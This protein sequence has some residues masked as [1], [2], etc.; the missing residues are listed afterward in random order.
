MLWKVARQWNQV[1][2]D[3]QTKKPPPLQ[4]DAAAP[5]ERLA[6]QLRMMIKTFWYS[7]GRNNLI[8]LGIAVCTVVALTA[9]LQIK[10]N[11]WNKPFYDALSLKDFWEFLHQLAVFGEIAGALLALNVA[12]AFLR[13]LSKLKLREGLTRDLFDQWLVPR[14]AF[15]LSNAGEIGQNPDQ[16]IHED[17]R[18][19]VDLSTD[20]GI[21]LLQST[22]LLVCFITVLWTVSE[23]IT[24]TVGGTSFAVPGY[25]VWCALI[26]AGIASF[27]SW[28]VGRP[29]IALNAERYA[30]EADLR[31][32]LVRVNERTEAIALYGGETD[33]KDYL[34]REFDQVLSMMRRL[35]S[36]VTRLTWVTAGYGWFTIVAPFIVA[37]PG[38]FAGDMSLGG[39][40]M[41]VGAFNQVQQA[42]RW[43]VDNFSTIADWRATLLRVASF[44]LALLEMDRLGHEAGRLELVQTADDRLVF[45]QVGI[46]SPGGCTR[47][48]EK[49][50]VINPA[51]RVLIIGK[52]RGVKTILFSA[53][54]GLWPFGRGRILLPPAQSMMFISQQ[55]YIPPD[56]LRGALAYPAE[57]AQFTSEEYMAALARMKLAHLSAGLDRDARLEQELTREEQDKLAFTRLLLH[58][59]RWIVLDEAIDHL[60]EEAR[61]LVLDIFGQELAD[62]AIINIGQAD[63]QRGFFRR[64]LHLIEDPEGERLAPRAGVLTQQAKQKA[65]AV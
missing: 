31:F 8:L 33:E 63:T 50:T 23:G 19:L 28:R 34:N 13:E 14:R 65:A 49:H 51:E 9:F 36:G 21:G 22:L 30:R 20:L 56:T 48:N 15:H 25:M 6:P 3:E 58:K 44:R 61:A 47:L 24:F 42:L 29:L 53:I 1:H 18:H 12:Q 32:R 17:A 39:L 10:L 45:D 55:D 37:A 5:G 52:Q 7:P 2:M 46:A 11:A 40:M 43:F 16:R 35:V 59:P 41:A 27:G 64:V 54:A 26:Y 38:Y 4:D 62:A 60:D 57:P